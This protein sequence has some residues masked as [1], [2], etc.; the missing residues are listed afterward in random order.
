MKRKRMKIIILICI[1]FIPLMLFAI[2]YLKSDKFKLR[3]LYKYIQD[4]YKPY[5]KYDFVIIYEKNMFCTIE[6]K[7]EIDSGEDFIKQTSIV[8]N[9][10]NQFLNNNPNY[11]LSNYRIEIWFNFK[12]GGEL[13]CLRNYSTDHKISDNFISLY[14]NMN[15]F[16]LKSVAKYYPDLSELT[17]FR[18]SNQDYE[19]LKLF[20]D[21]KYCDFGFTWFQENKEQFSKDYPDIYLSGG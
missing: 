15:G 9:K 11:L 14:T 17:Y 4:D 3:E 19:D 13:F 8:V 21:L 20:S 10:V 6:F 12:P 5:F 2:N 18:I 1:L 7:N 16:E